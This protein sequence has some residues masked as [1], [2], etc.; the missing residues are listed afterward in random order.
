MGGTNRVGDRGH[1]QE[2][3]GTNRGNYVNF[4][5]N[6]FDKLQSVEWIAAD[7]PTLLDVL[8]LL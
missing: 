6:H 1:Q 8:S 4:L 5:R 3:G 7:S 2:M